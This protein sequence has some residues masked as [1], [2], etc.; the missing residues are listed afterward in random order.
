M[1]NSANTESKRLLTSARTSEN[2]KLLIEVDTTSV[3]YESLKTVE[4]SEKGNR[5]VLYDKWVEG[6]ITFQLTAYVTSTNFE[7]LENEYKTIQMKK[8]AQE[9]LE[10]KQQLAQFQQLMQNP[11]FKAIMSKFSK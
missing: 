6:G 7:N 5:T 2:K 8:Q 3:N 10:L 11:E 1:S 4:T 9:N